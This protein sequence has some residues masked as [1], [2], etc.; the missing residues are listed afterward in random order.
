M[1]RRLQASVKL[2]LNPQF[3]SPIYFHVR[4]V[5]GSSKNF[6][7]CIQT[8][9]C[10]VNDSMVRKH[11]QNAVFSSD[12]QN[13]NQTMFIELLPIDNS[14][15]LFAITKRYLLMHPRYG[16]AKS[17][18]RMSSVPEGRSSREDTKNIHCPNQLPLSCP[19]ALNISLSVLV[20]T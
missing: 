7:Q 5:S 3:T 2:A 10:G 12:A 15:G 19:Q 6:C 4:Y 14:N 16:S 20:R 18:P 13:S 1:L 17:D 11:G 9:R 8:A